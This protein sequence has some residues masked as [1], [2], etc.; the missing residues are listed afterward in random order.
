MIKSF[1][2]KGLKELFL[3]GCSAKVSHELQT[4][5]VR[6]LDALDVAEQLGQLEI[7]GFNFH[8]LNGRPK[9]YNIH[10]NGPYCITFEWHNGDA[11]RVDL[12]NYH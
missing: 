8:G 9:R 11:V 1:L 4:R 5:A 6:R 7:P 2:H 10:V 3:K 12:E